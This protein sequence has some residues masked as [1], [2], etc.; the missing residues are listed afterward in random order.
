MAATW[1]KPIHN[2]QR[3]TEGS[4]G[5][6]SEYIMNPEKTS[7]S[8]LVTSYLCDPRNLS[9]DF[10]QSRDEYFT[11]ARKNFGSS[12][13]VAYHVRQAFLPGEV[14]A[15]LANKLGHEMAAE[16]TRGMNGNFAYIVATHNDTAHIHNHILI[17]AYDIEGEC[18]FRN[19]KRSYKLLREISDR[20]SEKYG[21]SVIDDPD[22]SKSR[23]PEYRYDNGDTVPKKRTDLLEA[24]DHILKH[25][26]PND[27]ADFYA[28]LEAVGCEIKRRGKSVSIRPKGGKRFIRFR[29]LP[30]G[31]DEASI[32]A[33][34]NI[35]NKERMREAELE[36]QAGA[37]KNSVPKHEPPTTPQHT[38]AAPTAKINLLIDIENSI[39]AQTSPDYE[40]WAT[41]FNIQQAAET[42]LFLQNNGLA[43]IETLAQTASKTEA[44]FNEIQSRFDST[45]T[46]MK[47]ISELQKHI[48]TYH[49]TNAI[50]SQYLRSKR[51]PDFFRQNE[52][53]IVACEK[54]KAFFDALDLE[55]LPS[56]HEL[57][58]EYAT[59]Q[60][61]KNECAA[62]RKSLKKHSA[63]LKNAQKNVEKFLE[64]EL[65]KEPEIESARD[66]RKR[67]SAHDI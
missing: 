52:N 8:E 13:I 34:I 33:R 28:K 17:N 11:V 40:R 66:E 59:L 57:Q 27:L 47:E 14:D 32:T 62:T 2:Q 5:K 29:T 6:V 22:H 35:N 24:I 64:I 65:E 25:Q 3:G 1:I 53:A 7:G 50:Y 39:K 16:L 51:N 45:V 54:A 23:A 10:M 61:Q 42:L 20:I 31:Y 41:G 48:G 44:D 9:D 67:K 46:R 56:I 38:F 12:E 60:A 19:P 49:K 4:V 18:K 36:K 30:D 63:D 37:A 15:E 26:N 55:K 21:L 58:I 43:D